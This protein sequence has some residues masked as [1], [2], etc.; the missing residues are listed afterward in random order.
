MKEEVDHMPGKAVWGVVCGLMALSLVLAS[1]GQTT[2]TTTPTTTT[3][4][5]TTTSV[6]TT[7]STTTTFSP[8]TPKYGGTITHAAVEPNGW[9]PAYFL[10]VDGRAQQE[11]VDEL[12]GEDWSL[13]P[14]GKNQFDWLYGFVGRTDVLTGELAESWEITNDGTITWHIRQGCHFWNKAPVNGRELTAYDI[15]WS[16]RREWAAPPPGYMQANFAKDQW[17]ISCNA[18]DKWTVV[19]KVP[20]LLLGMH[21]IIMGDQLHIYAR[22]VVDQYGDMKDWR[23]FVAVGAFSVTDYVAGAS[24]TFTR[25]PNYWKHD[26][27]H[28]ENQLPYIDSIKGL[29]ISDKSTY[30]SA[31][32]TAKIDVSATGVASLT[33]QHEDAVQL[34]KTNPMLK[35]I[36]V[37]TA[38]NVVWGRM[39][40]DLPFKN[41]KVRKALN[42]AIDRQ[43]IVDSYYGGDGFVL[44]P[45]YPPSKT[46]ESMYV[47]FDKLPA[48]AQELL[49]FNPTK[50][51]ALLAEAGYPNGFQTEIQC[52]Q[53]DADYMSLVKNYFA[54]INVDAKVTPMDATI[55]R[56]TGRARNFNQMCFNGDT[57]VGFPFKFNTVRIESMDNFAMWE[58]PYT[59]ALYNEALT[60]LA[61]DQKKFDDLMRERFV[62]FYYSNAIGVF[63]PG[64][65]LYRFWWPWVQ[66]YN[67]QETIGYDNNSQYTKYIWLDQSMKKSMGY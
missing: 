1:C 9:D 67:G 20:P 5:T 49:T 54:A 32:R 63:M 40:K 13:G 35:Y 57:S 65:N 38:G 62:P 34:M 19:C 44:S 33:V 61:R 28:P 18:T 6:T 31:L 41:L 22:E 56:S 10:S 17:L 52:N 26:P 27:D 29:F 36:K 11:C 58:D 64:Y 39:D 53:L 46:Y 8:E 60:Y 25:D 37:P 59:R 7:K 50:A 23:R 16:I 66:N 24:E 47:P 15:E 45:Y 42:M 4:G 48:D 14:Q 12:L 30:L 3:S 43:S 21:F 2:T 51:K 55:Y